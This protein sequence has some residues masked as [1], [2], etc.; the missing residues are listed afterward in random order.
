MWGVFPWEALFGGMLLGLSA[1]I[2][3]YFNGK[4]A[5]ISGIVGGLLSPKR[6]DID[7][8]LFFIAGMI[9]AGLA[10]N[11]MGIPFPEL[12]STPADQSS[13]VAV[14]AG[15]LV[16]VGTKL[17]NGCTSGH[18]ICGIGRLSPRSLIATIVFMA[19][20]MITVFVTAFI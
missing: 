8:R 10:A 1:L 20:A 12:A 4:V 13:L 3:L 6:G 11:S 15:L 19:S 16:G 17:A 7:W 18:G 2:L 9:V 5:G 14:I